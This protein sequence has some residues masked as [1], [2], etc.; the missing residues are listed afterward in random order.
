MNT[1]VPSAFTQTA[2]RGE[3]IRAAKKHT[4]RFIPMCDK[5]DTT[6][7][8]QT[9]GF[10]GSMPRMKEF[11]DERIT[12]EII[13]HSF[14]ATI[15]EYKNGISIK[16]SDMNADQTGQFNLKIRGMANEASS[17]PDDLVVDALI[18]GA[19]TGYTCYD[20]AEFFDSSHTAYKSSGTQDNLMGT[21]GAS[22]TIGGL[23]YDFDLGYTA[24]SK[25]KNEQGDPFHKNGLDGGVA[26]VCPPDQ[27]TMWNAIANNDRIDYH[28]FVYDGSTERAR[29]DVPNRWKSMISGVYP[30][31]RITT[32]TDW[33]MLYLNSWMKPLIFMEYEPLTFTAVTKPDSYHM[34]KYGRAHYGCDGAWCATY[35][36]W[37][38][39][40]KFVCA[41]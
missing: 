19:T 8:T 18:N 16:F 36:L 2:A 29:R 37:Q 6:T 17:F 10:L 4:P 40:I 39:A 27:Y 14:S 41:S 20:G 21:S 32:T 35:G 23:L 22:T 1:V 3:F 28:E 12:E 7:K 5:L 24:M 31:A 25:F 13:A 9:I 11:V 38:C 33:Y 34:Y 15:K 26:I 30:S